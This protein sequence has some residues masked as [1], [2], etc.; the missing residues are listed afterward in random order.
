LA[1]TGSRRGW[2]IDCT[3][4]RVVQRRMPIGA[5]LATSRAGLDV[6]VWA[7]THRAITLV[8]EGPARREVPLRV[9]T[10]GYH[11]ALVPDVGAGTR[12][13]FR[14]GEGAELL[15]DPASRFQPDGPFGPSEVIDPDAFAWT[16]AAWRG[17]P[18]RRHVLYELHIGTFTPEGTWAA[19]AEQ[20]R[21]LADVGITTIEVMPANEFA[22]H[23]NWGYDG[24]NLFAPTHNYGTPDDM[25]RFVNRA[26]A[27]GLAVILDVVY[28]HFGPS[29]NSMFTWS[30]FYKGAKIGEWGDDLNFDGTGAS[31]VREFFASNAAYWI[32]EFHLDGFRIDATQAIHDTSDPHVLSEITRAARTAG[33]GREIFLVGENEPQDVGSFDLGLDA[34]W[35]DDFHHTAR[36]AATGLIEGYLHDYRGTAQ[37]L[38]SAVKHGFLYQ[39]QMYPWQNQRRGTSTRRVPLHRFVHFLENHDQVANIGWGERL[40]SIVD[41]A[42]VR[43]LTALLLLGPELPLLFQGQELGATQRWSFFVDHCEE[44]RAPVRKGRAAF[45]GQFARTGT[46]E[47]QAALVDPCDEATFRRCVLDPAARRLEA[48]TVMMHRDLLRLRREDPALATDELDGAVLAERAFC[49]RFFADEPTADRLMLVNLGPTFTRNVVPEPLIA[50][51]ADHGWSVLWSSEHPRYGGHGTPAPI[52]REGVTIPAHSTLVLSPDPRCPLPSKNS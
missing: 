11:S 6:R 52:T 23:H 9:E 49:L 32:R 24:V 12:Y 4:E 20:L 39:G 17:I 33:R 1:R 29:G 43:A 40:S 21:Y 25:R 27:E 34:L 19:A 30:P 42:T 36:V 26:H 5:E 31:G 38:V 15:A 46:P 41:P 51:P 16:D 7:P 3:D 45:V 37:E 35:N 48:P 14:I 10:D 13:R 22:G 50:P 47:A 18:A 28:N 2:H 8:I 44:L